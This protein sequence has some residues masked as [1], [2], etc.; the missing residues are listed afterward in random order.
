MFV[1]LLRTDPS[2]LF[3]FLRS[4]VYQLVYN[5]QLIMEKCIEDVLTSVVTIEFYG[6]CHRR[7]LHYNSHCCVII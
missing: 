6:L 3:M 5:T 2:T 7:V 4:S 1:L